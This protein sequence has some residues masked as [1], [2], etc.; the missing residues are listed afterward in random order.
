MTSQSSY[1]TNEEIANTL[2]H[3]LGAILSVVAKYEHFAS[4]TSA[5]AAI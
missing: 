2:T 5:R 4:S 1:S 3:A